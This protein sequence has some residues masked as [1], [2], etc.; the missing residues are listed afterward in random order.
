MALAALFWVALVYPIT[1][2]AVQNFQNAQ[3]V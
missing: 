3:K 1:L 2:R